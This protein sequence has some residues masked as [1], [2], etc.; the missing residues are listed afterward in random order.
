MRKHRTKRRGGVKKQFQL[1]HAIPTDTTDLVLAWI[2]Q[3][4][5]HPANEAERY[6]A[7]QC[8]SKY[9]SSDT[10]PAEERE[11]AAVNKWL[12]TEHR[13]AQTNWRLLTMS[14]DYNILPRIAASNF[15][16]FARQLC[17]R[18]IGD[19]IPESALFGGFS[20]GASTS[21][22]RRESHPALKFVGQADITPAAWSWFEL[23]L[24]LLPMLRDHYVSH[25]DVIV[26][27]TDGN[28][29]FTV[30]K[31]TEID[32]VACK[33][34]DINMYLQRGVGNHF[35]R[36][37]RKNGIDL[38]DQSVNREHARVGSLTG[39]LATIDL[40]S[41]SDSVTTELVR[42][43]LPDTWYG[44][45]MDLRSPVT[46]IRCA[47]LSGELVHSNEMISSMGNGFTFELES[48]LFYVLARTTAYFGGHS[49]VIGVYG[50]DLIIPATMYD[51]MEWVLTVFGFSLNKGKSFHTG[52]FRESCGGHYWHGDDIT[53]FYIKAP[54][55]TITDVIRVAN[56]IRAW[57]LRCGSLFDPRVEEIWVRLRS[58]V[59][60][61]LWGGR[62]LSLDTQ[63]V[64]A[65]PPHSRLVRRAQK[66]RCELGSYLQW[67]NAAHTRVG[68]QP[69][70]HASRY[71]RW[72]QVTHRLVLQS[73]EPQNWCDT[74]GCI[75][76]SDISLGSYGLEVRR[77]GGNPF[78]ELS[79]IGSFNHEL[80]DATSGSP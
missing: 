20:G 10:L 58:L 27:E 15:L 69:I 70:T 44:L 79:S 11:V 23:C 26:R 21:R 40:S 68:P 34:P 28:V 49:G 60:R 4:Q 30:P 41:A 32:R 7:D 52:P 5:T 65:D 18:I 17:A 71:E 35:R 1:P 14:E 12:Q 78:I 75:T 54:I 62:D 6:L 13:N 73:C 74:V 51:D 39:A 8:F 43:V 2:S 80:G 53:P 59:P 31:N 72:D 36:C 77:I 61:Y 33:E 66:G 38:N 57:A 3:L 25:P 48:L 45:L 56:Q 16:S 9:V 37:L 50:D 22:A 42:Q 29:M 67:H 55:T 63:L 64:T 46:H 24:D 19:T 47:A 76:T